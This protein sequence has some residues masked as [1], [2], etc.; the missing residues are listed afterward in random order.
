MFLFIPNE[1]IWAIFSLN[2]PYMNTFE[3]GV[4]FQFERPTQL[5]VNIEQVASAT[6]EEHIKDVK[7]VLEILTYKLACSQLLKLNLYHKGKN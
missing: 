6:V 4:H 2:I 1:N 7:E 5:Q 3:D